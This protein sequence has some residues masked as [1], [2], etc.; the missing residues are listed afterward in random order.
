M[1]IESF[2]ESAAPVV[3]S[4]FLQKILL[5]SNVKMR[6]CFFRISSISDVAD[7]IACFFILLQWFLANRTLLLY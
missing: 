1:I 3:S 5:H 7:Y 4:G 6:R 2:Q